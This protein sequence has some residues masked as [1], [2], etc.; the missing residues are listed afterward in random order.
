MGTVGPAVKPSIYMCGPGPMTRSLA[1]G[2]SRLGV[3]RENMR[4]ED[5]GVR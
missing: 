3:P 1:R 4:W 5:F 2:F